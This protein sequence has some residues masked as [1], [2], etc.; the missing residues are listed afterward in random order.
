M[1]VPLNDL[2][3]QAHQLRDELGNAFSKVLDSGWFILGREVAAFEQGF[4]EFCG[5]S[6]CVGVGN[7]FDAL[8]IALSALE[9]GPGDEV[10]TTANA[11]AYGTLSILSTGARPIFVD[12]EHDTLNMSPAALAGAVG[13]RSRAILITHLHG[14]IAA[15]DPIHE[16]AARAAL[17]LVEDCSHAHGASLNGRAAGAWGDIGCFSFYPTKNLGAVGDAGAIVLDDEVLASN[18]RELRNYG[19]EQAGEIGRKH[20]RNSRLDEV[21][22]AVLSAK[23]P[24]VSQWNKRRRAICQYYQDRIQHPL[25]TW[26]PLGDEDD[27]A[28]LC[29]LQTGRRDSLRAHLHTAGVATSIHYPLADH[30]QPIIRSELSSQPSLPNTEVSV[31]ELV[32]LP[33]FPEMTEQEVDHVCRSLTDWLATQADP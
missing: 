25:I 2:G 32:T 8:G 11:G 4:A 24:F 17:R 10:I 13:P 16:I 20:G 7:G 9:L 29:V 6:H 22:A 5:R 19:W 31:K 14:R 27:A 26:P 3:R 23:L 28:H 12:V 30:Q 33:N 21:Q 15:M 18:I 1:K